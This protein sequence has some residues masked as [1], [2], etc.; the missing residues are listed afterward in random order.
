M[1]LEANLQDFADSHGLVHFCVYLCVFVCVP[2][3]LSV[4]LL[5]HTLAK[6]KKKTILMTFV[7]LTS[8]GV[9]AKIALCDLDL[10]F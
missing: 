6:I 2:V 1:L 9:S 8:N 7:D 4:L 3:C 5:K 10:L